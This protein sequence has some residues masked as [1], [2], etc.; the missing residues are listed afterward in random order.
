MAKSSKILAKTTHLYAGL[1]LI[2]SK[3]S[4]HSREAEME[5]VPFG[6]KVTSK[7]TKRVILLPWANVKGCELLPEMDAQE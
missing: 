4:I 3:T 2:G 6:I 5:I 1:E 7:K